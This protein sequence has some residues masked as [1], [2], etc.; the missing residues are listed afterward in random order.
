MRTWKDHARELARRAP[1]DWAER[2][3]IKMHDGGQRQGKAIRQT[4]ELFCA[5]FGEKVLPETAEK[6]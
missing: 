2:V 5:K 3:A 1:D 4:Y 6:P